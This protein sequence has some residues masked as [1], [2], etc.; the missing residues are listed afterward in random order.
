MAKCRRSRSHSRRRSRSH[1]RT[2]R[3]SSGGGT[4]SAL[5][6]GGSHLRL[7]RKRL[8]RRSEV[9]RNAERSHLRPLPKPCWK[10]TR[11]AHYPSSSAIPWTWHARCSTRCRRRIARF[12]LPR[13]FGAKIAPDMSSDC[14]SSTPTERQGICARMTPASSASVRKL[15]RRAWISRP[16]VCG[17]SSRH[18]LRCC[19]VLV[20]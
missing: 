10:S 7:T 20:G 12:C 6:S 14:L 16:I 13:D 15:L 5:S 17:R 1:L 3:T 8:A 9:L 11:L 2:T 19:S 18:G 4:Q